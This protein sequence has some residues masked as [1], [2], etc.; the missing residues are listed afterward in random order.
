[1]PV[2]TGLDLPLTQ[3]LDLW[4]AQGEIEA[5]RLTLLNDLLQ[6]ADA[7]LESVLLLNDVL[8]ELRWVGDKTP[9]EVLRIISETISQ[10]LPA[11]EYLHEYEAKHRAGLGDATENAW[12]GRSHIGN[13]NSEPGGRAGRVRDTSTAAGRWMGDGRGS[14]GPTT[15]PA[16]QSQPPLRELTLHER[17]AQAGKPKGMPPPSQWVSHPPA[18]EAL[19]PLRQGGDSGSS[20]LAENSDDIAIPPT[21]ENPARSADPGHSGTTIETSRTTGQLPGR[22]YPLSWSTCDEFRDH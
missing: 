12:F 3:V 15:E 22:V 9:L 2:I 5:N 17:V 11:V 4:I 18:N 8:Q 13:K 21:Q 20:E 6:K 16:P 10:R 7:R 14:A 19:D 1:M